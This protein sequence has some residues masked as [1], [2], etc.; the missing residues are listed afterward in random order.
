M[1]VSVWLC[2]MP[3]RVL[4]VRLHTCIY[5]RRA[6]I[7]WPHWLRSLFFRIRSNCSLML[8]ALNLNVHNFLRTN[9]WCVVVVGFV[10]LHVPA[11]KV[12]WSMTVS[13]KALWSII[14]FCKALECIIFF[15]LCLCSSK[16]CWACLLKL[17]CLS[18]SALWSMHLF[19]L[20]FISSCIVFCTGAFSRSLPHGGVAGLCHMFNVTHYVIYVSAYFWLL[21]SQ[22]QCLYTSPS[23]LFSVP[24][25]CCGTHKPCNVLPFGLYQERDEHLVVAFLRF[26]LHA[27]L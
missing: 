14:I 26:R 19:F 12:L 13:Y 8:L 10:F 11:C 18:A 27:S 20:L 1:Q 9:F 22:V 4:F 3:Q 25:I 17:V 7:Y 2:R 16:F 21:P 15:R 6:V 5:L 23:C 24:H